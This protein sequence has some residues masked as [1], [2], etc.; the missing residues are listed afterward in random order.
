MRFRCV[1]DTVLICV[2]WGSGF[3]AM[4]VGLR[5]MPTFAFVGMRFFLSA[6]AIGAYM[7]WRGIPFH[8]PRAHIG[9][10]VVLSALF[11]AQQGVL[12]WGM[13]YTLASRTAV[14]L[15]TQP[16][17]TAVL[18]HFFVVGDR[19]TFGKIFGLCLAL[20]GV[21]ALFRG[22]AGAGQASTLVGDLMVLCAALSWSVQ[23]V[24]TKRIIHAVRPITLV[25]WESLCSCGLFFAI[26]ACIERGKPMAF[27]GTFLFCLAYLVLVATAYS[28]V[29]WVDLIRHNDPSAVTSFC[30]VTPVAGVVIGWAVLGDPISGDI[31]LATAAVAAGIVCANLRLGRRGA[32]AARQR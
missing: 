27:S 2:I 11:F 26:S 25:F 4:K 20:V 23:T 6:A 8:F 24:L 22:D 16:I 29:K 12:F 15:N 14:I 3:T 17:L 31:M 13:N 21:Q 28:F 5:D 32:A 7:R 9:A 10:V 1:F 18:A 19:L 30:F